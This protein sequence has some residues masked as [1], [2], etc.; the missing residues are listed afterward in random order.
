VFELDEIIFSATAT[1]MELDSIGTS[2]A[3]IEGDDLDALGDQQ[4]ADVLTRL[5]GVSFEQSGA[6]GTASQLSIRGASARYVSVYID[7]ILVTDPTATSGAFDNFGGLTTGSI[8]RIE[9]LRGSQSSLYGGTAVAGV[10]NITTVAGEE[11][12]MGIS[13]EVEVQAGSYNTYALDY[14][15]SYRTDD[16]ILSFG[17]SYSMSDGF[18]AA[19]E[20]N[21]NTETDP[22]DQARLT[23]GVTHDINGTLTVGVNGFY[24][25][26]FNEFDEFGSAPNDGTVGD[27]T[28]ERTAYGLR[29]FLEGQVGE[30]THTTSVSYYRVERD[31]AAVTVSAANAVLGASTFDSL[32]LGERLGMD[33][34][35]SGQI[36]PALR[37]SAGVDARIETASYANQPG[38]SN[39][40]TTY[41]GF[42]EAS[43]SLSSQFDVTGT[44]RYDEHS[45][46]GG[47]ITGRIA[48]AYRPTEALTL[49]AAIGTGYRPPS[50]DE[51]FGD[52]PSAFPFVGNPNLTPET[53]L[54]YEVGADYTFANGA[55]I[56]VTAF[57]LSIEDLIAFQFAIPVSSLVNQPG[58][59]ERSGVELAAMIPMTDRITLTGAYTYTQ[60]VN[61][62]GVR[63]SNVPRHD[64]VLGLDAELSDAARLSV[65][66][67]YVADR[68][69]GS[70]DPQPYTDYTL[71][72]ASFGYDVADGIEAFFRVENLLDEQYQT[73]SGY[74]TSDRAFYV[75]LR[76]SF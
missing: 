18:S 4:V 67:Q 31:T 60:A 11:A 59:S 71:I 46:F 61:A 17:L 73:V 63:L 53:S 48:T 32:F 27:D 39:S 23:F 52:Y 51:L 14:G 44:L 38:G 74:G 40:T 6:P 21:G 47:Q 15:I 28:S 36:N 43:W 45:N 8:R 25:N 37:L 42:V 13:H 30:W 34:L 62:M 76:A 9:V 24:E 55:Q 35:V 49:R 2:V 19:D 7:G 65:T 20:N 56:S 16:T 33:Y 1:P 29:T 58:T 72:D 26:G 75:G 68:A 57:H 64:L 12:P 70:F 69:N 50:L 41:G 54:S 10:V 5:P 3:V 22:Y 66:G